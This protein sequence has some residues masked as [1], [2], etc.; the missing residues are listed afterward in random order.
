MEFFRYVG[1]SILKGHL[2][3]NDG[4][5]AKRFFPADSLVA[6]YSG[7]VNNTFFKETKLNCNWA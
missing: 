3:H 1:K 4:L 7:S 6:I 2:H 5:F